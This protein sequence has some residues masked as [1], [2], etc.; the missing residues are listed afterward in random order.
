MIKKALWFISGLIAS[1]LIVFLSSLPVGATSIGSYS[2]TSMWSNYT[3]ATNSNSGTFTKSFNNSSTSAVYNFASG[4]ISPGESYSSLCF[5]FPNQLV[6]DNQTRYYQ[7]S[8]S[9]GASQSYSSAYSMGLSGDFS[10]M[11]SSVG[12]KNTVTSVSSD[13][14]MQYGSS[15]PTV[16]KTYYIE[17]FVDTSSSSVTS[18]TI[19]FNGVWLSATGSQSV[20]WFVSRASI[21][22]Y[23]SVDQRRNDTLN[24]IENIL[25]DLRTNASVSGVIDA[26]NNAS[27][28]AHKDSQDTQDAIDDLKQQ[29]ADQREEDKNLVNSGISDSKDKQD[30]STSEGEEAS[31]SLVVLITNFFDIF[32]TAPATTCDVSLQLPDFTGFGSWDLDFCQIG[33]DYPPIFASIAGIALCVPAGYIWFNKITS[34]VKG[35]FI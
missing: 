14:N 20:P 27:D 11:G 34:L 8:F 17:G 7:M 32:L 1:L 35:L 23:E 2:A 18:H 19:C 13:T 4:N 12:T 28:T 33:F 9:I 30:Q 10:Q 15:D 25:Q 21:S 5:T 26:V 24:R 31:S 16:V 22:L 3:N 6:I 29:Q